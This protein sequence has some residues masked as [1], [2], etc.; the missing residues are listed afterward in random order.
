MAVEDGHV[1][2]DDNL[3]HVIGDVDHVILG[4]RKIYDEECVGL[5]GRDGVEMCGQEGVG[6]EGGNP[7]EVAMVY[8]ENHKNVYQSLHE[9]HLGNCHY[10]TPAHCHD[11]Q[12][13]HH[14]SVF[15]ANSSLI[16]FCYFY[17]IFS[18]T[19]VFVLS[20]ILSVWAWQGKSPTI[21]EHVVCSKEARTP[22]HN[23][24]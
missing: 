2:Q 14:Q 19:C 7:L 18:S 15:E 16:D 9:D 12:R 23:L 3:G 10:V 13:D 17:Y 24:Q 1:T 11:Y 5:C 22:C 4:R 6:V 21:V 8:E 20:M